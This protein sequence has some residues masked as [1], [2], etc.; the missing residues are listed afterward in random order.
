V[1]KKTTPEDFA[2][3]EHERRELYE[4]FLAR[5]RRAYEED[6][7][8]R[9]ILRRVTLGVLGRHATVPPPPST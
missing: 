3:W 6:V 1:G 4:R 8:Q 9:R 2:R 7:R 5:W